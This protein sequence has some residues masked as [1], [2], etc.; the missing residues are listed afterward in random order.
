MR[1]RGAAGE[2]VVERRGPLLFVTWFDDQDERLVDDYF[3]EYERHVREAHVAGE[4][5]VLIS[6]ALD[7]KA[8]GA[9]IRRRIMARTEAMPEFFHDVQIGNFVVLASAVVRGALTAMSWLS[10]TPWSSEYA[11]T[12]AEAIER[13]REMLRGAGVDVPDDPAP[14]RYERPARS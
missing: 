11:A 14:G 8:P 1:I 10:R 4:R 9:T 2:V 6:D 5:F 13:A 3:A 7:A 12:P